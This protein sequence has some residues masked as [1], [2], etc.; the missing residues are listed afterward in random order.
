MVVVGNVV[1]CN[2]KINLHEVRSHFYT[3]I[4]TLLTGI[5]NLECLNVNWFLDIQNLD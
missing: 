2:F 3:A 5:K 1:L 4:D